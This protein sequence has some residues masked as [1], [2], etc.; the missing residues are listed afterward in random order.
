MGRRSDARGRGGAAVPHHDERVGP[1]A[2]RWELGGRVHQHGRV[3]NV[4]CDGPC[5][6]Q[7][8]IPLGTT[9]HVRDVW[10]RETLPDFVLGNYTA[11][12][13]P[14]NGGIELCRMTPVI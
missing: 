3:A 2:R 13:V 10:K 8:G 14:P 7:T 11:M 6:S 9:M 1:D 12:N 4:T 5:F